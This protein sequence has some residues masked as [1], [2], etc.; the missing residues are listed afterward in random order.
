MREELETLTNQAASAV[1]DLDAS[2]R[3]RS[4][5]FAVDEDDETQMSNSGYD[6]LDFDSDEDNEVWEEASMQA[7]P[8]SPHSAPTVQ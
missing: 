4:G 7:T 5:T 1:G 3:M 2:P 6:W 8:T